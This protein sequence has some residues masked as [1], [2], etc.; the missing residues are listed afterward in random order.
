MELIGLIGGTLD[1]ILVQQSLTICQ[2]GRSEQTE[3]VYVRK[4]VSAL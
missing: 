2:R 3:L 4:F 1:K